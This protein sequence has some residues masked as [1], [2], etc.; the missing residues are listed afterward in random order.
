MSRIRTVKPELFQHDGLFDAEVAAGLPLRLAFVGLFTQCDRSGRFKWR[1][2]FLKLQVM[3][4]DAVDFGSVLD[5]LHAGGWL[6]RYGVDGAFGSI[7]TWNDHQRPNGR[8]AD[9]VLPSPEDAPETVAIT[10]D[11]TRQ[12]RVDHASSTRHGSARGEG[13]GEG[14]GEIL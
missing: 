2:R 5:A 1:P 10:S 8:E 12:P 7:P 13:E 6:V 4:Y 11:S 14:E 3:P 9:S